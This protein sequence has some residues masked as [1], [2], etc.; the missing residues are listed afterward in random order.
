MTP[1]A[2]SVPP[3]ARRGGLAARLAAVSLALLALAGCERIGGLAPFTDMMGGTP[4]SAG[5]AI[6]VQKG[7]NAYMLSRRY[8]VPLRDLIEINRL[9]PPYKLEVGQR[10][11][12]P[13]ARQYIVQKGDT[14]YGISRMHNVDVSELTTLNNLSPPYAV[15]AG[16]PL[17]LP[18]AGQ[19]PSSGPVVLADAGTVPAAPPGAADGAP[20]AGRGSI[21]AA[22]LPAPGAAPSAPPS[23]SP[24][25]GVTAPP[26][27]A[28]KPGGPAAAASGEPE[29]AYQPG[30]A[31]VSLRPPGSKPGVTAEPAPAP[32]APAAV[33]A[34]PLPPSLPAGRTAAP[35]PTEVAAAPP[36]PE[37]KAEVAAPP[38]RGSA[39]FLWPV[40]GKLISGYGPKPDGLHND[41]L[42]IAAGKGTAVVAADNGVVAYAGN[43]LRGFG[44]LLLLKHA[45]G[46]IT[47]YAHLDRID[48]ERGA[49]VKRGQTVGRVGQTGAVSSP[50]LHFELRKGSQAVDPTDQMDRR[51]I[52]GAF[53]DGPPGPG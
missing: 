29:V 33:A 41:G 26:P 39:R 45:D 11:T 38:P 43:E 52:E 1:A 17:R 31:P 40:K 15:Q 5:G 7:D 42:N 30:Q 16:Q 36:K 20:R 46:W 32:D 47:A 34:S 4:D 9:T 18:G 44:N 10:L 3:S 27:S 23:G 13:A 49:T 21:Q 12:L 8:N 53:R 35:A 37:P 28:A 22:E 51:P 24:G 14:L 48:V 50:Q 19:R 2:P 25:G 6:T